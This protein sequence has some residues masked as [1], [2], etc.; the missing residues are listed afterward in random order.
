[1]ANA[2]QAGGTLLHDVLPAGFATVVQPDMT[3]T[4]C[5]V[6]G[7]G[8]L[9]LRREYPHPVVG[10][11]VGRAQYKGGFAQIGPAGQRRHLCLGQIVRVTDHRQCIAL[12]G[13]FGEDVDLLKWK[14]A[15]HGDNPVRHGK[16]RS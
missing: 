15:L 3:G 6:P 12:K 10:F 13:F 4:Q 11:R 16:Y 14:C 2:H 8:Q 5:R 7:K 9:T 1:M